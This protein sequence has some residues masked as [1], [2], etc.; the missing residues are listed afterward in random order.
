LQPVV[1]LQRIDRLPDM[2]AATNNTFFPIRAAGSRERTQP[3]INEDR[4]IFNRRVAS[5]MLAIKEKYK[6]KV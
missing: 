2:A 6:Y 3:E 4:R 5:K 1:T